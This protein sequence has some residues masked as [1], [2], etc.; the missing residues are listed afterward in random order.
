MKSLVFAL[1]FACACS[2]DAGSPPAFGATPFASGAGDSGALAVAMYSAPDPIARV[3]TLELVVTDVATGSPAT[4][5]A[6]TVVPWMP[7]MGHGTSTQPTV[8]E[9]GGGV[10]VV[11]NVILFMPGEWQLRVQASGPTSDT[12]VATVDVP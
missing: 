1:L 8:V 6:I 7:A 3:S 11:S 4:G 9:Q 10:Y 5:L 2:S 12:F